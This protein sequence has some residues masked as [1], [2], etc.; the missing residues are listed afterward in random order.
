MLSSDAT[1]SFLVFGFAF[2][3]FISLGE[4]E[5]ETDLGVEL[6]AVLVA[7]LG[8]VV[9]SAEGVDEVEEGPVGLAVSITEGL[10]QGL[11]VVDLPVR[12]Q[13]EQ[14]DRLALQG[15]LEAVVDVGRVRRL[16]GERAEEGDTGGGQ[17][18]EPRTRFVNVP[19]LL[20]AGQSVGDAAGVEA[21]G[22]D[23][24]PFD[25]FDAADAEL[26]KRFEDH[27]GRG[28][29][30]FGLVVVAAAAAL[31]QGGT[32]GLGRRLLVAGVLRGSSFRHGS[33]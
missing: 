27:L 6:D 10:G 12:D 18:K 13:V 33:R 20:E 7:V 21:G 1:N 16:L 2:S 15:L 26:G 30:A 11:A 31:T 3:S 32:S 29:A 23:L 5:R 14:L 8:E 17:T 22:G 19:L 28:L 24:V 4:A 9:F 25:L